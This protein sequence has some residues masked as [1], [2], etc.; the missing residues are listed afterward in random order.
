MSL[1]V[2]HFAFLMVAMIAADLLGIW[3]IRHYVQTR[4]V[5]SLVLGILAITAGLAL[6]GY[7]IWFLR[8]TDHWHIQ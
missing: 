2:I 3:G 4:D 6:I 1:K 8:K 5:D 7:A